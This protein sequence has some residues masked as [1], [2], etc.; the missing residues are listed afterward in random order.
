MKMYEQEYFNR[1]NIIN[2][3]TE[4]S[5]SDTQLYLAVD[6][7]ESMRI[8]SLEEAVKDKLSIYNCYVNHTLK[9]TEAAKIQDIENIVREF[10]CKHC[11]VAAAILKNNLAISLNDFMDQCSLYDPGIVTSAKCVFAFL[12]VVSIMKRVEVPSFQFLFSPY[13][14]ER[15][16]GVDVIPVASTE[17]DY[18]LYFQLNLQKPTE[19]IGTVMGAYSVH[20]C[21]FDLNHVVQYYIRMIDEECLIVDYTDNDNTI[22]SLNN[23]CKGD[24]TLFKPCSSITSHY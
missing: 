9:Y 18:Y 24:S 7:M 1:H 5:H 6:V 8:T 17:N 16:K 11:T 21:M 10:L 4:L 12:Y 3:L 23:I 14:L 15:C 2:L 13:S 22:Y 19:I 20:L